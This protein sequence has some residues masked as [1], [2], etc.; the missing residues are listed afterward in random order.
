MLLNKYLKKQKRIKKYLHEIKSNH[1][2]LVGSKVKVTNK[3]RKWLKS[4]LNELTNNEGDK[5]LE[6]IISKKRNKAKVIATKHDNPDGI[7]LTIQFPDG[8]TQLLSLEDVTE[9]K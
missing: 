4:H 3:Y 1:Q 8:E 9:I 5:L 6:E 7:I 2:Q